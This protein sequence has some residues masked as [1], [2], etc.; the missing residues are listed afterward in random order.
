M[1][2]A[3]ARRLLY[4]RSVRAYF[5]DKLLIGFVIRLPVA[6]VGRSVRSLESIF[7]YALCSYVRL[8]YLSTRMPWN[9]AHSKQLR[10]DR[11]LPS[12]ILFCFVRLI[13][14]S[15]SFGRSWSDG[16]SS[17][18]IPF[19]LLL[20]SS[21]VARTFEVG[22]YPSSQPAMPWNW[23]MATHQ[24]PNGGGL[25]SLLACSFFYYSFPPIRIK[26]NAHMRARR[27]CRH[28]TRRAYE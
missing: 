19:T 1:A 2:A 14:I 26:P 15:P 21:L 17:L 23:N 7:C 24:Q 8:D 11:L 10:I 5:L 16:R 20:E 22:F 12:S 13:F 6:S 3:F 27:L 28:N 4:F 18:S 9:D 25:H